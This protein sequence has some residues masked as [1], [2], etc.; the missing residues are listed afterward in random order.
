MKKIFPLS[1]PNHQP[2]R[3][4]EQIKCEL[5]KYL[6]R[7]RKKSLPEGVDFWDFECKIG[8]D[9]ATPEAKHVEEL[10]P[11]ID[12]AVAQNASAIY[13]EILSKPGYRKTKGDPLLKKSAED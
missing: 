5:R 4:I 11:A 3:V 1:A 2:P 6:K 13:V 9:Q 8:R 7:E 12:E 10:I